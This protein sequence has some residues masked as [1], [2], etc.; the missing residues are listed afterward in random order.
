MKVTA[1]LRFRPAIIV[2]ALVSLLMAG[3]Q[4]APQEVTVGSQA[5]D[6]TLSNATGGE[7][8]LADY[9]GTPV[10]LFFHMAMG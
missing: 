6:F 3:C 10:L 5:P 1:H 2:L 8:S 9:R 4:A 7:V